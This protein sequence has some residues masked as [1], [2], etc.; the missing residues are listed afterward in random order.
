METVS[1]SLKRRAMSR[2]VSFCLQKKMNRKERK[3]AGLLNN[4]KSKIP[5]DPARCSS[6]V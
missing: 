2:I 6:F 3:K 5:R 1:A 4:D